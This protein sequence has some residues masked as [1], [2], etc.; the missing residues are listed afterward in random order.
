MRSLLLDNCDHLLSQL[1]ATLIDK[2]VKLVQKTEDLVTNMV[3][4][5]ETQPNTIDEFLEIKEF[6]KGEE[7][8]TK[9]EEIKQNIEKINNLVETIENNKIE[10]NA[11]I[12][13]VAFVG[14]IIWVKNLEEKIVD[15]E[16]LLENSRAKFFKNLEKQKKDILDEFEIVKNDID[17]FKYYYDISECFRYNSNAKNIMIKLTGLLDNI[18]Q[19]N[20]YEEVLQYPISDMG[21]VKGTYS[22]FE[23]YYLL[24][25][26]IAEKWKYVKIGFFFKK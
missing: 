1:K 4:K 10:Y 11:D 19:L 12:F 21:V 25:E 13:Q 26:F 7:L 3:L 14:R 24:W 17:S 2:F 18:K 22:D 20:K 5:L 23:K 9:I 6:I 16:K 8:M 15:S